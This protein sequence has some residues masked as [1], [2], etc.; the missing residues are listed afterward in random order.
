MIALNHLHLLVPAFFS[1]PDGP[2][3]SAMK[4][5]F[6][7]VRVAA[8]VPTLHPFQEQWSQ[9]WCWVSSTRHVGGENGYDI[10]RLLS[11]GGKILLVSSAHFSVLEVNYIKK[12]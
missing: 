5:F 3:E 2:Q 8:L 7:V 6:L 1:G 12:T 4:G 9:Q 10:Q 11:R